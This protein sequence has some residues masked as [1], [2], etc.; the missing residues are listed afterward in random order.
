MGS[1]DV[2]EQMKKEV[3][4]PEQV[5][6]RYE[7]TLADIDVL[8]EERKKAGN[9]EKL[10]QKGK[11]RMAAA[12]ALFAVLVGGGIFCCTNPVL[13]SKIPLVGTIFGQIEDRLSFSG[14]YDDFEQV[15]DGISGEAAG[16]TIPGEEYCVTSNGIT[17]TA[18]EIYCDGFSVY[19]TMK[20]ESEEGGFEH[21]ASYYTQN[22]GG[23]T[24]HM[25][26]AFGRGGSYQIAGEK[27]QKIRN[28]CFQGKVIDEHTFLGMI[29][30]DRR[31]YSTKDG[32]IALNFRR[33]AYDSVKNKEI[34]HMAAKKGTWSFHIPYTVDREHSKEIL[35]DRESE[36]GYGVEKVIVTKYQV[37]LFTKESRTAGTDTV[38]YAVFTQDGEKLERKDNFSPNRFAAVWAVNG[39]KI[40]KLHIYVGEGNRGKGDVLSDVRKEKAAKK[41]AG[42]VVKIPV[43]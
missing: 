16:E 13:A 18:S 22:N 4:V 5:W 2:F 12:A 35:V 10:R 39:K 1:Y 6:N 15:T 23:T 24:A 32:T 21:I 17:M 42:L 26:Y 37:V 40:E 19:V 38:D 33:L 8:S 31:E 9:G 43:E 29:K 28:E 20:I 14:V 11:Q 41:L 25:L 27:E 30:F 3:M 7:Q 36:H 34:D